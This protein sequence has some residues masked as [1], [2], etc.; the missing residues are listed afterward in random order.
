MALAAAL[1]VVG[2]VVGV[3][4]GPVWRHP[5]RVVPMTGDLVL[6]VTS[7]ATPVTLGRSDQDEARA[8]VLSGPLT[9]RTPDEVFTTSVVLEFWGSLAPTMWG[10]T[11]MHVWGQARVALH[12]SPCDG[13]IAW[14]YYYGPREGS[15]ALNLHCQDG[16]ALGARVVLTDYQDPRPEHELWRISLQLDQAS[17]TARG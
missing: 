11:V 4:L 7:L 12:G 1:V 13:P 14:S 8:G 2:L 9:L 3:A 5:V 16:S 15:G 10:P 6:D 17:Y